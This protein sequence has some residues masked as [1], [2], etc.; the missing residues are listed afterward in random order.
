LARKIRG[1]ENIFSA[2]YNYYKYSLTKI[3][4]T[5]DEKTAKPAVFAGLNAH[6]FRGRD[7]FHQNR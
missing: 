4:G 7:L 3:K 6:G 5:R 1:D 2:W